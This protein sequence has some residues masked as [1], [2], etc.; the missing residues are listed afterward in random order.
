M[1]LLDQD[2]SRGKFVGKSD[3]NDSETAKWPVG[4]VNFEQ[5][6]VTFRLLV[7]YSN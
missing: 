5:L 4:L 3:L 2:I 7:I 6:Y 1:Q